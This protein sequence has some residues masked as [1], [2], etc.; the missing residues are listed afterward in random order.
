MLAS[1]AHSEVADCIDV[2]GWGSEKVWDS[3][4]N[5][6]L[7]VYD[8][9]RPYGP[10]IK[11]RSPSSELASDLRLRLNDLVSAPMF[12]VSFVQSTSIGP[13]VPNQAFKPTGCKKP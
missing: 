12:L 8:C 4:A 2:K 1:D 7:Y 9:K 13:T 3:Y 6:G 10:Y 5:Q 11:I